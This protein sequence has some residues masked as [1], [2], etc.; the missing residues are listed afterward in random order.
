MT[1][2]LCVERHESASESSRGLKIS[3]V[4]DGEV[5]FKCEFEQFEPGYRDKADSE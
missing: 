5:G 3:S 1:F 4:I 2:E